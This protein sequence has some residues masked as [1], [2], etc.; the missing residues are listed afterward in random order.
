MATCNSWASYPARKG[1]SELKGPIMTLMHVTYT[2]SQREIVLTPS[3]K[4]R[5]LKAQIHQPS[6]IKHPPLDKTCYREG[7]QSN[8][9]STYG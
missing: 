9:T 6:W 2:G 5:N 4:P 3:L 7:S 8:T 1:Y